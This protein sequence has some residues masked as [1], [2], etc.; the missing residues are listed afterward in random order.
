MGKKRKIT[1]GELNRQYKQYMNNFMSGIRE[2]V[3]VDD[4]TQYYIF[5]I[6]LHECLY[7]K[8]TSPVFLEMYKRDD[9]FYKVDTDGELE[10]YQIAPHQRKRL[11]EGLEGLVTGGGRKKFVN[12]LQEL[13]F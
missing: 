4:K 6:L 3:N 12:I 1:D 8:T 5:F 7:N 13:E 11:I 2:L 9:S 10:D